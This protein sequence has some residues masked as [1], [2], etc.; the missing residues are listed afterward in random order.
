MFPSLEVVLILTILDQSPQCSSLNPARCSMAK[1][2]LPPARQ[3]H[4]EARPEPGDIGEDMTINP[5][6]N[7]EL[8]NG[9]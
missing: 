4:R 6:S 8:K 3:V 2:H 7:G 1:S 9:Y 5:I